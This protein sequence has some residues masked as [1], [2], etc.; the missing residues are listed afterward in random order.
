MCSRLSREREEQGE[1]A[2]PEAD[3]ASGVEEQGYWA[4][5]GGTGCV[6]GVA[7]S[8]HR[9][10]A[11]D[12]ATGSG[13]NYSCV[14]QYQVRFDLIMSSCYGLHALRT[15]SCKVIPGQQRVT[16]QLIPVEATVQNNIS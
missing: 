3:A 6:R 9:A 11:E 7:Q 5:W 4:A 14:A 1:G 10:R 8:K 2:G 13:G 16:K 15:I 12:A